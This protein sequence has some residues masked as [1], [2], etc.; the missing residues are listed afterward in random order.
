MICQNKHLKYTH[1]KNCFEKNLHLKRVVAVLNRS[2]FGCRNLLYSTVEGVYT[3]SVHIRC[4][5]FFSQV[6]TLD[7]PS[8][9]FRVKGFMRFVYHRKHMREEVRRQYSRFFDG[10]SKRHFYSFHRTGEVSKLHAAVALQAGVCG[11]QAIHEI[12]LCLLS[13]IGA[14]RPGCSGYRRVWT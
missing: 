11:D 7:I 9:A 1:K 13:D 14:M 3:T 5:F 4:L 2:E 12:L 6:S 10:R 8:A